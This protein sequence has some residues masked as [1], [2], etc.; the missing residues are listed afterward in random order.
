MSERR[1]LED[2][3]LEV[4]EYAFRGRVLVRVDFVQHDVLFLFEFLFRKN[5]V[6]YDVGDQFAAF[7]QSP[8]RL[9]V[10]MTV[11]SLVV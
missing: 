8:R 5:G 4:V 2:H 10:W 1:T 3:I 7:A 11:S 6:E 9:V